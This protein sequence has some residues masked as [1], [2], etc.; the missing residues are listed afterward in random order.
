MV[1]F[2]FFATLSWFL[3]LGWWI[4]GLFCGWVVWL[5][6][7]MNSFCFVSLLKWVVWNGG[8]SLIIRFVEM[9][10]WSFFCEVSGMKLRMIENVDIWDLAIGMRWWCTCLGESR[11]GCVED[12]WIATCTVWFVPGNLKV[13]LSVALKRPIYW[14]NMEFSTHVA[15]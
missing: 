10:C 13:L 5:V 7:E 6:I 2:C 3:D 9:V 15:G 4:L 11:D 12:C 14:M 1:V 8:K